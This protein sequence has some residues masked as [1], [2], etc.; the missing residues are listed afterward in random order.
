MSR[1]HL[2]KADVTEVEEQY[3]LDAIR[4]GWVAPLGPDV[5]A[6]ANACET[7]ARSAIS[8]SNASTS[9]PSGATQPERIASRMYCSSTS[10]TSALDRWMRDIRLRTLQMVPIAGASTRLPFCGCP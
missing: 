8:A 4:S 10:V 9:G 6:S 3:I 1:I 5:D 2:S 7:P